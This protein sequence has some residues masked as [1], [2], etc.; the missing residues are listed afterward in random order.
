[1]TSFWKLAILALCSTFIS[2]HVSCQSSK[3]GDDYNAYKKCEPEIGFDSV[4]ASLR[5]YVFLADVKNAALALGS[6]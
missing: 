5:S 4:E 2:S 6:N 1:M 3:K